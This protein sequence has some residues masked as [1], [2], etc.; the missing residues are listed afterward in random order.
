MR[1]GW[2]E[3]NGK[4]REEFNT[5]VA[6]L[7]GR[8]MER[9]TIQWIVRL[10]KNDKIER[11][12]IL[13][14]IDQNNNKFDELWGE[15]Y[16]FIEE[17]WVNPINHNHLS[18]GEYGAQSRLLAGE[19]SGSLVAFITDLVAPRLKV[20]ALSTL[21]LHY[22]KPPKKPKFIRDLFSVSIT[23]RK[24]F[25][26][27]LLGLEKINNLSFLISLANSLDASLTHGLDI[28]RRIGWDG[29]RS[30]WQLGGLKRVYYISTNDPDQYLEGISPNVKLLFSVVE[31]LINVD[32]LTAKKLLDR[33]KL[34][35]SPVHLRL[36]A[37]ISRN[38]NM[39]C[40]K[41]VGEFLI[42]LDNK[43]FWDLNLFPE[44]AEL[45]AI[46]FAEID[47]AKQKRILSRIRKGPPRNFWPKEAIAEDVKNYKLYWS[48]RELKRIEFTGYAFLKTDKEW[49]RVKE[50]QLP[51]PV[52]M[53][54]IDEGFQ[55]GATSS[56]I[57]AT[58]DRQFDII[59]GIERLKALEKAFSSRRESWDDDPAGRATDWIREHNNS[60]LILADFE[61]ISADEDQFP[62][63]WEKFGWTHSPT[64]KQDEKRN[65][66]AE[67]TRIIVLLE[68]LPKETLS[69]A[70]EGIIQLLSSWK[71]LIVKLPQFED[72]WFSAWPVAVEIT[73]T[74]KPTSATIEL[75]TIEQNTDEIKAIRIDALNLPAGKLVGVFLE[76][77]PKLNENAQPF[78]DNNF[79]KKMR[80]TAV[81]AERKSG[82]ISKIRMI[83]ALQ[84]FLRA[85]PNWAEEHLVAPLKSE[86]SKALD[87][88]REI[89]G[90]TQFTD[91]IEMIGEDMAKRAA[92]IRLDRE[93]RQSLAFSLVI[94]SLHALHEARTPAV[95]NAIVQ[96]M[97]RKLDDEVR[98]YAADA[99]QKFVS[100]NS[101]SREGKPNPPTRK[102]LF[103]SAAKPFL[104]QV[105]PQESS[106]AIPGIA[107]AFADLPATTLGKFVEAVAVIERFLVPF[108]CWAMSWYGF[109]KSANHEQELS[110][111]DNKE[112]A[113][114]LLTLLNLTIGTNEGAVIP[115]DLSIALDQ[116]QKIAPD[117][118][119]KPE[120]R[121]LETSAR[122]V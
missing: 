9:E 31:R 50:T 56:R 45:R 41:E 22:R 114:A 77:C 6:F 34:E 7:D 110:M 88:W 16:N 118:A 96:Q 29:K 117:I 37:A 1:V 13:H 66:D 109:Y 36:W 83:A 113:K 81:N 104:E 112:K 44:I 99:I 21:S 63:V 33:W 102:D 54:K 67:A 40:A 28:A 87:L 4:N 2:A 74:A 42:S 103:N 10:G 46:R 27:S 55:E 101:I 25:N 49:L 86:N 107:S 97:I 80:D 70:I 53:T 65:L 106:L 68:K 71:K 91:V 48:V 98:S 35:S 120:F 64:I 26:P 84:Y 116:I 39:S 105:W 58:P 75:Q 3:I 95:S 73:N 59:K 32:I 15:A 57:Q 8:L 82:L 52:E 122:K 121:R 108:E 94:E 20:E 92:D 79:L 5:I 18:A 111:I 11:F 19:R 38:K 61:S 78:A 60:L 76:A 119:K 62:L 12:A 85:D 100:E 23:S 17:S 115:H 90:R 24:V 47:S 51:K 89:A 93:T 43:H 30:L 72:V 14:L 69:K